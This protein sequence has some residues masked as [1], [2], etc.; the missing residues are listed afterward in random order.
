MGHVHCI[1]EALIDF[2]CT[3]QLGLRQGIQFEKNAG[4]APANVAVAIAKLGGDTR[5]LGQ[6]GQDDFGDHLKDT[7][8]S[9]GVQIQHM[10]QKGTTTLAFVGVDQVGERSFSFIRGADGEYGSDN[11]PLADITATDIVHF[12][13]ALGFSGGALEKS[14]FRLRDEATAKGA[15]ISFDPNYRDTLI[16]PEELSVYLEKVRAFIAVADF[17]KL[18]NEELMLITGEIDVEKGAQK[19]CA[20]GA[21]FVAVTLGKNGT[22]LQSLKTQQVVESISIKQVDSTGAGDAFTG[23]LLYQIQKAGTSDLTFTKLLGFLEIANVVGALTCTK[24]GAIPAL[25]SLVEV[26]LALANK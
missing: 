17:V 20:L 24:Y 5:F 13:A 9:Y 11:L 25:P 19:I 1:G 21:K 4:G 10:I 3:D 18:S 14:Y 16:F 2:V 22:H 12:G 23:A 26:E 8:S 7:L 6:V 15:F